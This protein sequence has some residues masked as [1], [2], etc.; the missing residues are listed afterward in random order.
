MTINLTCFHLVKIQFN[1]STLPTEIERNL[2]KL[3]VYE[4]KKQFNQSQNMEEHSLVT[5][6]ALDK[7]LLTNQDQVIM[8]S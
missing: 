6:L 4:D 2:I 7:P 5:S 1:K 3:Y 8:P